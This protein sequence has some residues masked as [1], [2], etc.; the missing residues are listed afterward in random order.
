M[1]KYGVG[2]KT[3]VPLKT[4]WYFSGEE[5]IIVGYNLPHI[6]LMQGIHFC[7]IC[8]SVSSTIRLNFN[9]NSLVNTPGSAVT[10]STEILFI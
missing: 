1:V 5:R 6:S 7:L 4:G 2:V 3:A 8:L 9:P 10:C